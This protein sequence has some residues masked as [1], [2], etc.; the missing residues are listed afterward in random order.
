MPARA[1]GFVKSVCEGGLARKDG[2]LGRGFG[3][4][5]SRNEAEEQ[6]KRAGG[7]GSPKRMKRQ[8][9]LLEKSH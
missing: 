3:V 8:K 4:G 1:G 9:V 7:Q 5:G 2:V 6:G